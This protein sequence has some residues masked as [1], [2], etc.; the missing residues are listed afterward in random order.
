MNSMFAK[1]VQLCLLKWVLLAPGWMAHGPAWRNK[2]IM[3]D[4]PGPL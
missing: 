4:I 3:E 2:P 1:L